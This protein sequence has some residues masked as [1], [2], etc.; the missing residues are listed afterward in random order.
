M[1]QDQPGGYILSSN[2]NLEVVALTLEEA[3][4]AF[5][6]GKRIRWALENEDGSIEMSDWIQL[7]EFED[8]QFVDYWELEL[9]EGEFTH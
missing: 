3:L 2:D 5:L 4:T 7:V 8:Q 6:E 9:D 1:I